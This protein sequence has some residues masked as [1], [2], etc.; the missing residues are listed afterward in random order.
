MLTLFLAS[1]PISSLTKHDVL[2]LA[3]FGRLFEMLCNFYLIVGQQEAHVSALASGAREEDALL[4]HG[5]N[6]ALQYGVIRRLSPLENKAEGPR[7]GDRYMYL[8][9]SI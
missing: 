1:V 8:R 9:Y 4:L 6:C 7:I 3:D 5:S 2:D